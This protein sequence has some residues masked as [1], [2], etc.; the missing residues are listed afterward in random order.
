MA[1]MPCGTSGLAVVRMLTRDLFLWLLGFL[2][3]QR[4]RSRGDDL[5]RDRQRAGRSYIVLSQLVLEVML[6]SFC[7]AVGSVG[8]H[9]LS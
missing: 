5:E 9:V 2:T 6:L 4:L 3:A 1:L 8:M 7:F